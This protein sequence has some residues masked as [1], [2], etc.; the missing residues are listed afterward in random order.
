M[1]PRPGDALL[2]LCWG[3][4]CWGP[5]TLWRAEALA[6]AWHPARY[7]VLLLVAQLLSVCVWLPDQR[8]HQHE[9]GHVEQE[10]PHH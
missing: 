4:T 1:P 2:V 3:L 8:V 9:E 6:G 5:G 7:L 10:G